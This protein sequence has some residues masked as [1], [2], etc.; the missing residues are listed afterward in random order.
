M[1][2]HVDRTAGGIAIIA[3]LAALLLPVLSRAK[4]SAKRIT[5]MNNEHQIGVGYRLA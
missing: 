1:G 5:C 4:E 2:I 3:I